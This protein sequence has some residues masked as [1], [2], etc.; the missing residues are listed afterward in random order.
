MSMEAEVVC[1]GRSVTV[2]VPLTFRRRGGRKMVVCPEGWPGPGLAPRPARVDGTLVKALARAHRWQGMLEGGEYGSI[3]ELA[4]VEKINPSYL[5]RVLR[6][7]LL[8]PEIVESILDGRHDPE[9]T[10]LERLMRPFPA[11]WM[12]QLD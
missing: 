2:Q 7:T 9:R 11:A 1:N 8:A 3:E 10:T 4:R 6:L 5:A 12:D